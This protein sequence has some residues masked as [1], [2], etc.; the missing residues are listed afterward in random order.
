MTY[1]HII[2][3]LLILLIACTYAGDICAMRFRHLSTPDGLSQL[4]VL[5]IYQDKLG[6]MWF[7][8]EEGVNIFDGN[9][10][11]AIKNFRGLKPHNIEVRRICGDSHGNIY[12]MLGRSVVAI[13]FLT[14]R[15]TVLVEDGVSA[16][17]CYS[18]ILY[19]A[20]GT[21]IY[22]Y[23]IAD[24]KTSFIGTPSHTRPNYILVDH[25]GT[26]WVGTADGLF[27]MSQ[28]TQ[29][30]TCRIKGAY[31]EYIYSDSKG[32]IWA[33]SRDHGCYRIAPNGTVTQYNVDEAV[34]KDENAKAVMMNK[35]M[36]M[37]SHISSNTV[38]EIA[39]DNHGNIW[40]GTFLGLNKLDPTTGNFTV[41]THSNNPQSLSHQSV[42]P[43]VKDH[44]GTLWM[45]TYYGG[46]NY[47]TP[48]NDSFKFF[49]AD[50]NS[51]GCLSSP[52]VGHITADKRG[53]IWVCTEGGGLNRID[54]LSHNVT[55]YTTGNP[56]N[57]LPQN[58]LKDILYDAQR[59]RLYVG[60][61][62]G[63][64]SILD[65]PSGK[66]T[67]LQSINPDAVRR[68]GNRIVDM[69]IWHDKALFTTLNGLW[70]MNPD[71]YD[72]QM[73]VPSLENYGERRIYTDRRGNLWAADRSGLYKISV[74]KRR[75]L[76]HY[77][78]G[79][80]GLGEHQFTA[81]GEDNSGRIYLA[82]IGGGIYQLD[83][84]T[85]T[86][87]TFNTECSDIMS[88]FC[89]D[90]ANVDKQLAYST[91]RGIGLFNPADCSF[92]NIEFSHDFPL[93]G[94]NRGCGMFAIG[95]TLYA[96]GTNGMVMMNIYKLLAAKPAGRPYLSRL[97]VNGKQCLP[98]DS[99]GILDK[100]AYLSDE[101][102]LNYDQN[103]ITFRFATDDYS[104]NI[105]QPTFEYRLKGFDDTWFQTTT[106]KIVYPKLP[107]GKY[108]LEVRQKPAAWQTESDM[109]TLSIKLRVSP[110][111]YLS[112]FAYIIYIAI[113]LALAWAFY[114]FKRSQL[115]LETSLA[116]EKKDRQNIE[117]LNKAKLQFF[118][119]ISHEFRTPLT[120]II[121]K[122]DYVM[123]N[124]QRNTAIAKSLKSVNQNAGMMLGLV[125]ELLDFRKMEQGYTRLSVGSHDLVEFVKDITM[126][127][128]D[129]AHT[130]QIS[131]TF[132]STKPKIECWFDQRQMQKVVYN[133]I[134]NAFKYVKHQ[135]GVIEVRLDDTDDQAIIRVIDNGI[136]I[137]S[138]DV[139]HIFDRFYQ[140]NNGC[141]NTS[142]MR[143]TGIGLALVKNIVERHHGSI[144]VL[145][146]EGCGSVFVVQLPKDKS[147]FAD[148]EISV[149]DE[150][151]VAATVETP[152]EPTDT[153]DDMAKVLIVEDNEELLGTLSDIFA[154]LYTVVLARNG[155]EGLDLTRSEAP[156]IVVSDVMMPVMDGMEMCK[157]IKSDIAVCHTPI[158]LLTAMSAT[159]HEVEGLRCGADD[160]VSKPFN[161]SVLL[162]R[163][164]AL[165]RMRS[166]LQQRF[167]N[168]GI[169]MADAKQF[170]S[171]K[172]DRDFMQ[173]CDEVVNA[174]ISDSNCSIDIIARELLMSRTSFYAK[175]KAI[176][177]MTPNEYVMNRRLTAAADYL[178]ENNEA[179]IADTAY[180]FGFSSPRYFS[181]CFKK[182]YGA[183]PKEWREEQDTHS[184]RA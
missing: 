93:A 162:A 87:R 118:T 33:S 133:L 42:F 128:D 64:V 2:R 26:M 176:T 152:T 7:G 35:D 56:A 96:G 89:Y 86:F 48:D 37:Q 122:L 126:A 131:Y 106:S 30:T 166:M 110:P 103:N 67:N 8:T 136:G 24:K 97:D 181:Q 184:T 140:A 141:A 174:H 69:T 172:L 158:L 111:F 44:N 177:G 3:Q 72:V 116:I 94:I 127:F 84:H 32:N 124:V 31:V 21:H 5:S 12:F 62:M 151:Q 134:S 66:F 20:R 6:R 77:K 180:M 159:E 74:S 164:A 139:E 38:R 4:S 99:T 109:P 88:N 120:L 52:F 68:S 36:R 163:V 50:I 132:S 143:G 85:H 102:R 144:N 100:P 83:E 173:R 130:N 167:A 119:S 51:P 59:D 23:R 171:N 53:D 147:L 90:F 75:V 28:K 58:N 78:V 43:L 125:N 61:Y 57:S 179:S 70:I 108:T 79:K 156:D 107:A 182:H 39:E 148:D 45:G 165:L 168:D 145:S 135:T 183:N 178:R 82:S 14:Q 112:T 22:S 92:R 137:A 16:L 71:T 170:A 114:H 142:T 60:T 27:T 55:Y 76:H 104:A 98:D 91:E 10:M 73:L 129:M 154:P 9:N 49:A 155:K 105:N 47:F 1:R 63:S 46:V 117:A 115:L 175:F 11:T 101:I 65:I 15:N 149:V 18:D 80:A 17:A 54:H 138:A 34:A 81:I 13:D 150:H 95:G 40:M 157:A 123:Q 29:L 41:Y 161:P 25:R 113:I 160:Y 121:A 19:Y 153:T 146:S 169:H